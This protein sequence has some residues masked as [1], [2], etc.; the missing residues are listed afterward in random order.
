[1]IDT[2]STQLPPCIQFETEMAWESLVLLSK[3]RPRPYLIFYIG[4]IFATLFFVIA[5]KIRLKK[6]SLVMPLN[7]PRDL[8]SLFFIAYLMIIILIIYILKHKQ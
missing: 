3:E 2:D 5:V 7:Q 1:M 6:I 4:T 8:E